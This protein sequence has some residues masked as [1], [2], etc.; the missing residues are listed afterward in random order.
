MLLA[1]RCV[2][3]GDFRFSVPARELSRIGKHGSA[4]PISLGSRA[5]DLLH[6]FLDRPGELISKSEIMDAV[7]PNVAVEESNL[8]V[9]IS[10]LRRA[11]DDG[12]DGASYIQTVPGRGYRFVPRGDNAI[13]SKTIVTTGAAGAP[14]T[15][16]AAPSSQTLRALSAVTSG[17]RRAV[18]WRRAAAGLITAAMVLVH[19]RGLSADRPLLR[20][21]PPRLSIVALP[22]MSE[23]AEP[24]DG[25]LAAA[26]TDD[27][28]TSLTEIPG[29]KVIALS[30]AQ[31]S[32][33]RKLLSPAVGAELGVRYVLEGNIRRL[34]DALELKIQLNDSTSGASVWARQL[35]GSA[36]EPG[37][38]RSQIAQ[39][40]LFP[41]RTELLDAEARRLSN[42]PV[43]ALNA[44][45]LLLQ[46]RASNNHPVTP[47]KNAANVAKLERALTL[48]PASAEVMIALAHEIIVPILRFDERD[49]RD[50]R[51]Q[52]ART[53][54]DRAR[55][56]A[57]G[58]EPLLALQAH[59]LHAEERW[60]EAIAAFA[61]LRRTAPRVVHYRTNLALCLLRTGR[62]REAIPLL[63]EAVKL[64][65]DEASQFMIYAALGE[66]YVRM[67]RN[68]EGIGWLRAA[69]Q[70]SSGFSPSVNR[71]LAIAYAHAGKIRD[72]GRELRDYVKQRPTLTL[73]GLRHSV[74][75][76]AAR[77]EERMR[78][79]DALAAAGLRDRVDE[80]ADPGLP[81]DAGLRSANL[82]APTPVGAP[83]VSTIRTPELS[84]LFLRQDSGASQDAPPLVLWTD[85][86]DCLDIAFP[87][88]IQVPEALRREPMDDDGRRAL[89]SWVNRTLGGNPARRLITLSWNAERWHA[90]NLAIQLV[91]LGYPNVSWY[92]GGLEAW[93]AAGLPL[94]VKN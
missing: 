47:A 17:G 6:L 60:D 40:L 34:P 74:P 36:S 70:Q 33:A 69:Q 89:K 85:C 31:A 53:L 71:W 79:I 84:A 30:M 55:T 81:I 65:R 22:F 92:R 27:V 88:A 16:A 83:G 39:N 82:S 1:S 35:V 86:D 94:A 13:G 90:R 51:L 20:P 11:L 56:V 49:D 3:F 4:T 8:T 44:D 12:R 41:L 54:A 61:A 67:G 80:D 50:Q 28:A 45:D 48:E 42:L 19:W 76:N 15:D 25:E 64:N 75:A 9:Q 21:E 91:A 43:S 59:I 93:E 52:H 46:V 66:A 32:A 57:A 2:V 14:E 58:S 72:A 87:G 26:I 10:A 38:L 5:A 37:N 24:K 73:R 68:D 18:H 62:S 77:A 7:W 63:E 29:S 23:S 78:E